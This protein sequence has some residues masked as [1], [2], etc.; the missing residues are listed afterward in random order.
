MIIIVE[1]PDGAGKSTLITRLCRELPQYFWCLR[2]SRRPPDYHAIL[3]FQT[4][5]DQASGSLVPPNLILDRHPLISEPIYGR[6]IRGFSMVPD[7]WPEIRTRLTAT[8]TPVIIYCRPRELETIELRARNQGQMK[9]VLE[10]LPALVDAYDEAMHQIGL[11]VLQHDGSAA[12]EATLFDY[13][14]SKLGDSES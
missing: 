13:L 3:D 1:G 4:W 8:A 9:G 14:R 12:S 5:L 2:A 11:L 7:T 6:I 10:N